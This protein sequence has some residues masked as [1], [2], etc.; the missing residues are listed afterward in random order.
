MF[1]LGQPATSMAA[2]T[3]PTDTI[4]GGYTMIPQKFYHPN[5][6]RN[7]LGL[8]GG[9]EVSVASGNLVD[10]ESDLKN[11]TRDLSKAPSRQ[12]QP[13]CPLGGVKECPAWPKQLV[14]TDR[15]NGKLVAVNTQPRH[16]PTSQMMSY[17][18]VPAPEP[19]VQEVYGSPWRF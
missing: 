14:F 12:Y 13:S 11:I 4:M 15:S 16:L 6:S 1:A 7:A 5:A 18:G 9:N 10:V 2:P 8:I 19:F 3:K 17:P